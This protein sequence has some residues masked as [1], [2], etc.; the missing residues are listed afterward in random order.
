VAGCA[1]I[2][3]AWGLAFWGARYLRGIPPG[4]VAAWTVGNIA[5][6]VRGLLDVF[7]SPTPFKHFGILFYLAAPPLLVPFLGRRWGNVPVL[8]RRAAW[9]VPLYLG[10]LF[11]VSILNETKQFMPLMTVVIPIALTALFGAR[12]D[13]VGAHR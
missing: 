12:P 10:V 9:F 4:Y 6:N 5:T 11:M 7:T 1:A 3:A 8:F 2:F 13:A